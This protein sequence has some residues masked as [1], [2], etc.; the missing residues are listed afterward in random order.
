[1]KPHRSISTEYSLV[2]SIRVVWVLQ[3]AD[4][5]AHA[6]NLGNCPYSPQKFKTLVNE[7]LYFEMVYTQ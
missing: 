7:G 4:K 2:F 3:I 1:M 5:K 6:G